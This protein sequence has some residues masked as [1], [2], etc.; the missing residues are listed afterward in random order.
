MKSIH[1]LLPLLLS[2]MLST[3]PP[4][5]QAGDAPAAAAATTEAHVVG[6]TARKL[7]TYQQEDDRFRRSGELDIAAT[8][9]PLKV[10][11]VSKKGYV[12]VEGP[13]GPVWLD[14]L[15][16]KLDSA[17]ALSQAVQ[18][19]RRVT[20]TASVKSHVGMGAGEGCDQ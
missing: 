4:A 17:G 9:L 13:S 5:A 20:T 3:L 14:K 18:C 1:L 15:D 8:V 2:A 6:F 11:S 12:E 7:H 10:L 19:N 16:V